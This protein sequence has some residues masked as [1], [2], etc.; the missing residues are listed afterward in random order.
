MAVQ[1]PDSPALAWATLQ[2]KNPLSILLDGQPIRGNALALAE[3]RLRQ[4]ATLK[5]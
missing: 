3:M 5:K 4:E 1:G 2:V